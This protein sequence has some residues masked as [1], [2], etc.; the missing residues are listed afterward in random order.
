M[1]PSAGNLSVV[2]TECNTSVAQT[3][4][5]LEAIKDRVMK[6]GEFWREE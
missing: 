3:K 2:H 6:E 5:L 4:E 1:D